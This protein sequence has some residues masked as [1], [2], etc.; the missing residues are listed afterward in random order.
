[1]RYG[2]RDLECTKRTPNSRA[3][4]STLFLFGTSSWL[5]SVNAFLTNDIWTLPVVMDYVAG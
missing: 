2:S 1:M 5:V 3:C 4:A